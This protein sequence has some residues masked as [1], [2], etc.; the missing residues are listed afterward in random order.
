MTDAKKNC[1]GKKKF[2]WRKKGNHPKVPMINRTMGIHIDRLE[3]KNAGVLG[4]D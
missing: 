4:N 1:V 3:R 2:L